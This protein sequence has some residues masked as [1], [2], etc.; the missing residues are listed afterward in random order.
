MAD[1]NGGLDQRNEMEDEPKSD[2]RLDHL[3]QHVAF[4]TEQQERIE[5]AHAI[6]KPPRLEAKLTA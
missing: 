6:A 4:L 2:G 3:R 5:Q 1:Q